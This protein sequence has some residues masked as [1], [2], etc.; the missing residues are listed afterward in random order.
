VGERKIKT[1]LSYGAKVYLISRELTPYLKE[2]VG[3]GRVTWLAQT[4]ETQFLEDK[5]LILGATDNQ[6]LNERISREARERKVLCNIADN[7]PLCDFILPALIRRG[8]LTITVS[9][10]GKSPALAKKISRRLEEEFPETY[11]PYLDLL[12]RIRR[13][14]LSLGLTQKENQTIFEALINSP[15]LSWLESGEAE[16]FYD[17]LDHLIDPPIPRSHLSPILDR[18]W[19]SSK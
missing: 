15:I 6:E 3:Q 8:D 2:E 13:H 1:L 7:P 4:Y 12:G 10:G 9:T 17:L 14:V 19:P 16:P 5:F 18:L 11:G